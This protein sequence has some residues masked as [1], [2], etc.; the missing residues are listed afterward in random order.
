MSSCVNMEK[1]ALAQLSP[2]KITF[3]SS[4]DITRPTGIWK[5][6]LRFYDQLVVAVVYIR[7]YRLTWLSRPN[8]NG[9]VVVEQRRH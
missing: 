4:P 3:F 6:R 9:N 8:E 7:V 1:K 5:I 2:P